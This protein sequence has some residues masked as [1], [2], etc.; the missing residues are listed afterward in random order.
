[1]RRRPMGLFKGM[2]M[3]R[4]H[5]ARSVSRGHWKGEEDKET[6]GESDDPADPGP[7]SAR[8][9]PCTVWF[10]P[11]A[12][13]HFE[14]EMAAFL[15]SHNGVAVLA[16]PRRQIPLRSLIQGLAGAP[17]CPAAGTP[18]LSHSCCTGRRWEWQNIL[19][20]RCVWAP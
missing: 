11:K 5:L 13:E 17:E 19:P 16:P 9:I 4:K 3:S 2:P 20:H 18:E 15:G 10:D 14:R 6:S 12:S 7:V 1:M 8:T